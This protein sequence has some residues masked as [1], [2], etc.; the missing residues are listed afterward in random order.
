MSKY[1]YDIRD[2][3]SY[4]YTLSLVNFFVN[5][6]EYFQ[7]N[8]YKHWLLGIIRYLGMVHRPVF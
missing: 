5:N 3:V 1:I 2:S 6:Q 8:Q 4:E 7:T